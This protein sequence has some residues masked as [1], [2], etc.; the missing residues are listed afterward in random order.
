M[1]RVNRIRWWPLFVVDVLAAGC[2]A[3]IWLIWGEIRQYKVMASIATLIFALLLATIWF[4]LLSRLRWKVRLV[5]LGV[6]VLAVFGFTQLVEIR[7]VTGDLRPILSW[8]GGRSEVEKLDPG[9]VAAPVI[10]AS[11]HDSP[12]FLGP[13]RDATIS[14]VRLA[15]EW[16]TEAPRE[17]WRT[18]VGDGWASYAIWGDL[19]ITQEQRGQDELVVAYDL[20]TGAVRWEHADPGRFD[21]T[22]G[23]IGP[24]AT[25]AID[26]TRVYAMGATGVLNALDIATGRELWSHDLIA[27]YGGA[28]PEWGKSCSPLLVDGLVVV[29]A[30]GDKGRSLVAFDRETGA[31]IWRG[32]DDRSSYASPLVTTLVGVRQIVMFNGASIAGHDPADG[33]VLWSYPWSGEQ[34]NVAQPLPL[35]GDRLLVSSG[36]GVGAKMLRL[37]RGADD[38]FGVELIWETPRLKAKFAHYVE[39]QGSIYGLDDGVFT[40]LDPATGERRWKRGRYGHGQLLLVGDLIV[41]QAESGDVVL[42]EPNPEELREVGRFT[43][44]D[45]KTWNI[46]TLAGP[47][48]LVRNDREAALFELPLDGA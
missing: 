22:I 17:I 10:A 38:A 14:G 39:F 40:C 5:G 13:R 30:G 46:P 4:L 12:Q 45:R 29:S 41:L 6:L 11:A 28:L 19:A 23:G 15:R 8:K 36:Y 31:E 2:L 3:W 44:F 20:A 7:G 37:S 21:T 34:P 1:S 43:A 9:S 33:R 27:E 18:E 24:R 25:P 35:P 42:I 32:G 48:L 47:Y 16:R 26:G